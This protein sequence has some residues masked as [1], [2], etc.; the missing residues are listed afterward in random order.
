MKKTEVPAPMKRAPH[1][2]LATH[3]EQLFAQSIPVNW[4]NK[5]PMERGPIIGSLTDKKWR[6]AIGTHSGSYTVYRAL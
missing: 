6:N 2:V 4:G 1:V 3:K 5:E